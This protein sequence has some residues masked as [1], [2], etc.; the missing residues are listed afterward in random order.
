MNDMLLRSLIVLREH[1]Q[2]RLRPAVPSDAD[3]LV[4][5]AIALCE[6][7]IAAALGSEAPMDLLGQRGLLSAFDTAQP[8]E[9]YHGTRADLKPGDLLEPGRPSNYGER[10][11]AAFVYLTGSLDTAAWGA[12]LAAGDGP[13]RIYVV[14][15]TGPIMEDPDLTRTGS[16]PTR[17]Y[18]SEHPLRVIGEYTGAWGHAPLS[19]KRMKD[20]IA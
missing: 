4:D 19:I 11:A 10:N 13:G 18:R 3:P 16:N 1:L 17:S 5:D 12:E 9:F 20:S 6:A 14:Q 15:P 2:L 8:T 7:A